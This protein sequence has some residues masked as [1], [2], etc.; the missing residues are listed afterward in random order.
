MPL[1][2]AAIFQVWARPMDFASGFETTTLSLGD[3]KRQVVVRELRKVRGRKS[4]RVLR[5]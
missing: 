2:P 5:H 4:I 1:P 3:P